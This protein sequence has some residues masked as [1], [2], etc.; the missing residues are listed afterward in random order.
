MFYIL[1]SDV[2]VF[3]RYVDRLDRWYKVYYTTK[4]VS[5]VLHPL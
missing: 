4:R 2:S 1:F 3:R 5:N